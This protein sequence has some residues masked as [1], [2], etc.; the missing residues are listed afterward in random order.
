V[1]PTDKVSAKSNPS[2]RLKENLE[3][4]EYLKLLKSPCLNEEIKHAFIFSLYTGLRWVDCEKMNWYDIKENVVTTRM[5]Q[6]KTKQPVQLTLHPIAKSI[7]DKQRIKTGNHSSG[8]VFRL[9][10]ADGANKILGQWVRNAGIEKKI[11]WS[12][13]RLSFSILLLDARVDDASVAYLMGH[14]TTE[15]V[16][17]IYKRHRPKDQQSTIRLLPTPGDAI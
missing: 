2:V 6:A 3:A 1:N 17:K 15:M 4:D 10:C 9:P 5:L 13:A 8:K 12:C 16:R 14:M 11:T 7:L